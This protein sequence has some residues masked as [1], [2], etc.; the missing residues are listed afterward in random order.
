[1]FCLYLLIISVDDIIIY[2]G[3]IQSFTVDMHIMYIYVYIRIYTYIYVY[4][5]YS[6][7]TYIKCIRTCLRITIYSPSSWILID[8]N[9]GKLNPSNTTHQRL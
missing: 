2:I 7:F 4:I 5:L 6:I 8:S 1:M 9:E 3:Y